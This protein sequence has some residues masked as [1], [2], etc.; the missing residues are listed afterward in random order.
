LGLTASIV[1][2]TVL[3]LGFG[4]IGAS[5]PASGSRAVGGMPFTT[6]EITPQASAALHQWFPARNYGLPP[7][8]TLPLYGDG[9]ASPMF[10]FDLSVIP[11]H[12][13]AAIAQATLM[14]YVKSRSRST[15]N[16]AVVAYAVNRPW[17]AGEANWGRASASALWAQPGANGVPDDRMGTA[18]PETLFNGEGRWFSVDVTEIVRGWIA[19]VTPNNGLILKSWSPEYIN[20]DLVSSNAADGDIPYQPKLQVV[21]SIV[22]T[23]TPTNTPTPTPVRPLVQVSM[24]GPTGPLHPGYNTLN[25]TIEVVNSGTQDAS[26]LVITDALPVGTTFLN[27][28]SGCTYDSAA[29]TVTWTRDTLPMG[30]SASIELQ[31]ELDLA[32]WIIEKG[33]LTNIVRV[34]CAETYTTAEALWETLVVPITPTDTPMPTETPTYTPSPTD[35]PTST[36]TPTLTAVPTATATNTPSVWI[37]RLPLIGKAASALF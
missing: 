22:P 35:T 12:Q 2:A 36:A 25:Y 34:S 7:N 13:D 6:V 14:V 4:A 9:I 24:T 10:A 23:P 5:G 33:I 37:L 19:G 1:I 21:Y 11:Y 20:Y 15:A 31:L 30:A 17:V 18:S 27:C 8:W 28:S 29:Q 16:L 32:P 3:L 26:G